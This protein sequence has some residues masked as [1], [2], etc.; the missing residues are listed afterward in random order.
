LLYLFD[1]AI[2]AQTEGF[3]TQKAEAE[4]EAPGNAD[5]I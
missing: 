1:F 4:A 3:L 5:K 2:A